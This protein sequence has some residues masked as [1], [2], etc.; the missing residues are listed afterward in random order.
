MMKN[1]KHTTHKSHFKLENKKDTIKKMSSQNKFGTQ[2]I[3]FCLIL[4][5]LQYLLTS[6]FWFI[7]KI[8]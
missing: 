1:N 7:E 3:A 6:C 4:S 8:P 2:L 5:I